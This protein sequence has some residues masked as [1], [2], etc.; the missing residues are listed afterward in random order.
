MEKVLD[1][2]QIPYYRNDQRPKEGELFTDPYF[3]PNQNSLHGKNEKGEYLDKVE[4]EEKAKRI[5]LKTIEWKRASEIFK[6]KKYFLFED[7][8]EIDDVKQGTLGDCYFLS[9]VGALTEFPYLIYNMFITKEINK[10]GYFEIIFYI[11]GKFQIVVVDDYLPFSKKTKGIA[12]AKPNKN[13]IWVCILEKAWAKING[14]YNNIISGWMR[15][16]L[17]AFTGYGYGSFTHSKTD[18]KLLWKILQYAETHNSIMT[19]SSAA[20]VEDMGL[21]KSHAYTIPKVM[22]IDSNGDKVNLVKLRNTWGFKEWNGDWSDK[23]DKWGPEELA[24]VQDYKDADD[25]CFFMTFDD[26]FKKYVV[27]DVCYLQYS[28]H[29]KS[30]FID[31]QNDLHKKGIVLSVAL[32]EDGFMTFNLMRKLWRYNRELRGTVIPSFLCVFKVEVNNNQ[33]EILDFDCVHESNEDISISKEFKAGLY[34]VYAYRDF[35]EYKLDNDINYVIK[36]DSTVDF[37]YKMMAPDEP[38]LGFPYLTSALLRHLSKQKEFILGK[39]KTILNLNNLSTFGLVFRIFYNEDPQKVLKI[40]LNTKQCKNISFFNAVGGKDGVYDYYA[41]PQYY[42]VVIGLR[43]NS[44][45]ACTYGTTPKFTLVDNNPTAFDMDILAYEDYNLIN[46]S[47][48]DPKEY[49]DY[50]SLSLEEAEKSVEFEKLEKG[51]T[52]EKEIAKSDPKY[53]NLLKELKP[54]SN[55]KDLTWTHL[56][57]KAGDYIGQINKAKKKEGRG[58]LIEKDKYFIGYFKNDKKEGPGKEFN[59]VEDQLVYD[60][61]FKDNLRDGKG[62]YFYVNGDTFEGSFVKGKMHGMGKHTFK[63]SGATWE[64][65]YENNLMN[66]EGT[67][68]FPSGKKSKITYINGKLKK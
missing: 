1:L 18:P 40:S 21:V 20:N 56:R 10:E 46:T 50:T 63:K 61:E 32:P 66:G 36:I 5:D 29:S 43:K 34:I 4:G 12:Y 31:T 19:G 52:S 35:S 42:A 7:V 39:E 28:C 25:G 62:K 65:N 49:Y 58:A 23:S 53:F 8:I 22:K 60:G 57:T 26:Y 41:D 45:G 37:R 54:V 9:S 67:Q 68:T 33:T 15:H 11:D 51:N 55:D 44:K 59:K 17:Q 2:S 6:G 47:I 24:Q 48:G 3:P 64:G 38:S 16:A 14:G 13:E 30:F 27:T